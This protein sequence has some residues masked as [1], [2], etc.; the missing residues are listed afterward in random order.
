[1]VSKTSAQLLHTCFVAGVKLGEELTTWEAFMVY[2]F[3]RTLTPTF[4]DVWQLLV[5]TRMS[6]PVFEAVLHRVLATLDHESFYTRGFVRKFLP[7]TP[8]TFNVNYILSLIAAHQNF[9]LNFFEEI[10]SHYL[11]VRDSH[12]RGVLYT[13]TYHQVLKQNFSES[14]EVVTSNW[15]FLKE[16]KGHFRCV[17]YCATEEYPLEASDVAVV[18]S[19]LDASQNG[20]SVPPLEILRAKKKTLYLSRNPLENF[21][22]AF[23]DDLLRN[24]ILTDCQLRTVPEVFFTH[25]PNL[26]LVRLD[27]NLL[28]EAP[29]FSSSVKSLTLDDNPIETVSEEYMRYVSS[30]L[31]CL[32]LCKTQLKELTIFVGTKCSLNISID[33]SPVSKVLVK[34]NLQPEIC[35]SVDKVDMKGAVI[36][37]GFAP[38][39]HLLHLSAFGTLLPGAPKE[40]DEAIESNEQVQVRFYQNFISQLR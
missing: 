21:S 31:S 19:S 26:F 33:Y 15:E 30:S 16:N 4:V 8:R 37:N 9:S 10:L 22:L 2:V 34:G 13:N 35:L 38:F 25:F 32:Y 3:F 14:C 36:F 40:T 12:G 11:L 29:Q 23:Q 5:C 7:N 20:W 17:T 6:T 27:K 1:M 39:L 18:V 24:L 28:T